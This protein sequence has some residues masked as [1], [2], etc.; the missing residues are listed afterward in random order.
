MPDVNAPIENYWANRDR[1]R[2]LQQQYDRAMQE[3]A[4]TAQQQMAMRMWLY[5]NSPYAKAAIDKQKATAA[6]ASAK[7]ADE[8]MDLRTFMSLKPTDVDV[9]WRPWLAALQKNP[10]DSKVIAAI[11]RGTYRPGAPQFKALQTTDA[12]GNPTTTGAIFNPRSAS[13]IGAPIGAL[14]PKPAPSGRAVSVTPPAL[15]KPYDSGKG[16]VLPSVGPGATLPDPDD[17]LLGE[18]TH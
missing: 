18:Y 17:R 2:M 11:L 7:Q 5:Q 8:A 3:R 10:P 9:A 15:S 12:A 14:A 4:A 13:L 16:L 1:E 6:A